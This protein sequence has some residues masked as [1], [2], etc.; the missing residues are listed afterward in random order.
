M[1]FPQVSSNIAIIIGPQPDFP[2]RSSTLPAFRSNLRRKHFSRRSH[3][4]RQRVAA[5]SP[6]I[7]F[8]GGLP[9]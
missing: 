7:K 2:V 9:F 6:A 1:K 3:L 5:S 4:F 8:S